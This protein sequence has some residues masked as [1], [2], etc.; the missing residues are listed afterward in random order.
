MLAIPSALGMQFEEHV[1]DKSI[2][3]SMHRPYK[4][5]L[6]FYLHFCHKHNHPN[7][8]EKSLQ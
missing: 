2:E 5:W 4:K 1:R 6:R 8:T 3:S 7:E